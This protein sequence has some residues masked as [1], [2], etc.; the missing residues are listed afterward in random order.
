MRPQ[1]IVHFDAEEYLARKRSLKNADLEDE[2]HTK[3]QEVAAAT[4]SLARDSVGTVHTGGL[5]LPMATWDARQMYV[6]MSKLEVLEQIW[7]ERGKSKLP[8]RHIRDSILPA[9]R[10]V[11]NF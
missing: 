11:F 1:E 3:R 7:T 8:T 10:A 2:I 9:A 4:G 5:M 6:E